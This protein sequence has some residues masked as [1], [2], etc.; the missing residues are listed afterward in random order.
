MGIGVVL[1]LS[2]ADADAALDFLDDAGF[3]AWKIGRI[4]PFDPK[5][6]DAHGGKAP[7]A[8]DVRFEE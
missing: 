7:G 2:P 5:T 8:G 1:A 3:P 4:V 6:A